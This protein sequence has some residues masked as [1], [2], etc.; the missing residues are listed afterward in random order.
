MMIVESIG[1]VLVRGH[2]GL[3]PRMHGNV[4]LVLSIESVKPYMV[5]DQILVL[6][7]CDDTFLPLIRE[8]AGII[9]QNHINDVTSE[10]YVIQIAKELEKPAIVRADGAIRVLKEGQLVTLDPE[11]ALVYKGVVF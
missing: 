6:A 8:S 4:A 9:L 7:Q 5:R 2:N 10:Q 3:G 11:K 1:D